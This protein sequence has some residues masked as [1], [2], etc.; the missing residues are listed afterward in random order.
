MG[1]DF[2]QIAKAAAYI[3]N[4]QTADETTSLPP[5]YISGYYVTLKQDYTV[6]IS[7]GTAYVAGRAVKMT[8]EHLLAGSD[9]VVPRLDTPQHYYIYL[10]KSGSIHVDLVQPRF[11]SGYGYYE[12]PDYGWRA[13]GKLF[14]KSNDIIYA[15]WN[16][17]KKS[18]TVTVAPVGYTGEA[19]YYCTGVNDDILINSAILYVYTAYYGGTVQLLEGGFSTSSSIIIDYSYIHLAGSGSGTIITPSGNFACIDASPTAAIYDVQISDL[20]IVDSA[21]TSSSTTT[22]AI[23]CDYLVGSKINNVTIEDFL[24]GIQIRQNCSH[25]NVTNCL[26]DGKLSAKSDHVY[27]L[28]C[29]SSTAILTNNQIVNIRGSKLIYGFYVFG[30]GTLQLTGNSFYNLSTSAVA[31]QCHGVYL[32]GCTYSII[33]NNK[34]ELCKNATTAALGY[35]IFIES[36]TSISLTSNYCYNNGSDT[37][38]ANTNSNNFYDA[39]TDTQVYS[40]SWQSPVAGEPSVGELHPHKAIVISGDNPSLSGWYGTINLAAEVPVGAKIIFCRLE[41]KTPTAGRWIVLADTSARAGAFELVQYSQAANVYTDTHGFVTLSP[42]RTFDW[43]VSNPD[44][45]SVTVQLQGYTS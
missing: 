9:W 18:S 25:I 15:S 23:F 13:I 27:A 11:N 22:A 40:N 4:A 21:I 26:L 35:G 5:G 34:M 32:S 3:D 7:A 8:E 14:V 16:E 12:Q 33:S 6:T 28:V 44:I 2:E 19:D 37:G 36:G 29:I 42:T 17:D 38:I 31:M 41:Y 43:Y 1:R 30:S 45:D 20:R 24:H 39:G 10:D